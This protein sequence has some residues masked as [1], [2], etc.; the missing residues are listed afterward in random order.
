M[1]DT[2]IT[3]LTF[4]F[5]LSFD[6]KW[7]KGVTPSWVTT[8][9]RDPLGDATTKLGKIN[10]SS[11][12]LVLLGTITFFL[13]WHGVV[14]WVVDFRF[15]HKVNIRIVFF[16]TMAMFALTSSNSFEKQLKTGHSCTWR[17]YTRL[18]GNGNCQAILA[19]MAKY[20][21]WWWWRRIRRMQWSSNDCRFR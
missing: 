13:L 20:D 16:L 1:K 19:M 11:L 14:S 18:G 21:K 4:L 5:V 6:K 9:V 17:T 8:L 10:C 3:I 15:A 12:R 2:G 7:W